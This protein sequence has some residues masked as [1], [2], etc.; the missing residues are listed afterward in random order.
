MAVIYEVVHSR[1]KPGAE[2]EMLN[3]RPAFVAAVKTRYPELLDATLVRLDD[4]TWLDIVRWQTRR[5]ADEAAAE[6][7]QIPEAS[8]MMALIDEMISHHQ[9]EE[10]EPKA[11]R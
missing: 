7:V 2:S 5:S 10:A 4:G 9:G 3:L 8:A 6:A 11:A 1:L